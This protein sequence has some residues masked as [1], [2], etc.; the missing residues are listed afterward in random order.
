MRHAERLV[1]V[2]V[3]A[4]TTT[5]TIWCVS[6]EMVVVLDWTMPRKIDDG[7]LLPLPIFVAVVVWQRLHQSHLGRNHPQRDPF[8]E[9][10]RRIL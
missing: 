1:R 6:R 2:F 5:T 8:V 10:R 9:P 7:A 3:A 4:A